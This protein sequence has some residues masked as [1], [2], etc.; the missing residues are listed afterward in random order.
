[1]LFIVAYL[2]PQ[3]A[4][5]IAEHSRAAPVATYVEKLACAF[6]VEHKYFA[7]LVVAH[8]E[9]EVARVASSDILVHVFFSDVYALEILQEGAVATFRWRG[10]GLGTQWVPFTPA[11]ATMVLRATT[12]SVLFLLLFNIIV[13]SFLQNWYHAVCLRLSLSLQC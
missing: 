13:I 7:G 4:W 2:Q 1:M 12:L 10:R 5:H 11:K 6:V 8:G 3:R 9:A